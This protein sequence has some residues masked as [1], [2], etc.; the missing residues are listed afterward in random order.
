VALETKERIPEKIHTMHFLV[1]PGYLQDVKKY[2]GQLAKYE[3]AAKKIGDG[4]LFVIIP[5]IRRDM[6]RRG[7]FDQEKKIT[8]SIKRI[9]DTLGKRAIVLTEQR[10]PTTIPDPNGLIGVVR[11]LAH[12]RGF[13]FDDQTLTKAYGEIIDACV[14]QTAENIN[15][16]GKFTKPTRII[17]SLT[18]Y[19]PATDRGYSDNNLLGIK[20]TID[21]ERG[22]KGKIDISE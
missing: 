1:H 21:L 12:A 8:E 15:M 3:E 14:A 11:R 13:S 6:I 16:A 18:D 7:V 22:G 10:W 4:E 20:K 2:E 5:H 9:R 17:P 19:D